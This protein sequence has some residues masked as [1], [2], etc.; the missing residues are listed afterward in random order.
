MS[1]LDQ[2]RAAG[3]SVWLDH[4]CRALLTLTDPAAAG[5]G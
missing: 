4:L 3:Q 2:L 5:S 1:P